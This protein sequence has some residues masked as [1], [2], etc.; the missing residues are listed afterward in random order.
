MDY[1]NPKIPEGINV[2]QEHPL[3]EFTYLVIGVG[4]S[5]ILL[6]VLV[7]YTAGYLV[8]FIPFEYEVDLANRTFTSQQTP[9]GEKTENH[10]L[11]EAY[12]QELTNN[13]AKSQQLPEGMTITAHYVETDTINAL[14]TLGGNIIIFE[15]LLREM[16]S[17]N[18]LAMVVAH[19]IAH[20]KNRDPLMALGRGVAI[21]VSLAAVTGFGDSSVVDQLLGN[22]TLLTTLS[23]SRD[24]EAQA[25][26]DA[27]ETLNRHYGHVGGADVLFQ[28]FMEQEGDDY[29]VEFLQTHPLSENRLELVKRFQ[30]SNNAV[31]ELTA[32]PENIKA[33]LD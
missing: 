30:G 14:A 4:V 12:L 2:S 7:G 20:I 21:S 19:E 29:Q 26:L 33:A 18:A 11:I 25:D 1:E 32:I 8:K 13:I 31:I 15:G 22:I 10:Q 5:L 23:F 3:K 27:L 24:Q 28:V 17:E 9:T 16:P 6:V